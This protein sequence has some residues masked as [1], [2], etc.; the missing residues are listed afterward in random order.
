MIKKKFVFFQICRKGKKFVDFFK[1]MVFYFNA[2]SVSLI[3]SLKIEF[4]IFNSVFF[5]PKHK[6]FILLKNVL[7]RIRKT[8]LGKVIFALKVFF[9]LFLFVLCFVQIIEFFN[10][11]C[12]FLN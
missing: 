2:Y 9:V 8:H 10:F 7:L 6:I 11:N 3:F 4:L 5:K 1:Q 12:I